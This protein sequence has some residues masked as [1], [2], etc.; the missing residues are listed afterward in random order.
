MLS[1]LCSLATA[2]NDDTAAKK[3]VD[4][5]V[6][7]AEFVKKYLYEESSGKLLRSV[8]ID[9]AAATAAAEDDIVQ[10]DNPVFGFADDYAYL[11][12]GLLDL[13]EATFDCRWTKL[14]MVNKIDFNNL[15]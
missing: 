10:T 4:E 5:A 6:K 1:G 13:Y 12:R 8:Y 15:P 9:A 14:T 2:L 3:Y 7:T 11:V